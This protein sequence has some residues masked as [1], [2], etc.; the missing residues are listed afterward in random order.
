LS[1]TDLESGRAAEPTKKVFFSEEK[2][3]KTF[4]NSG[5]CAP[6]KVRDSTIA[7]GSGGRLAPQPSTSRHRIRTPPDKAATA[8]E[9][10]L[11]VLF[12][13]KEHFLPCRRHR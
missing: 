1:P 11:L 6:W 10:S 2:K 3:Q 12:Y 5:V 4:A 13:R 8:T 9:K 7:P